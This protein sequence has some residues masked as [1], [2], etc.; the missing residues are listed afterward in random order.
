[1]AEVRFADDD[2]GEERA[3]RER[4]TEQCR[5]AEG[6]AERDREDREGEQF[7]RSRAHDTSEEPWHGAT[8]DDEHEDDEARDLGEGDRER[9]HDPAPG[10]DGSRAVR[11]VGDRLGGNRADDAGERR[12][13]DERE[14]GDE[15]LDDQPPDRDASIDRV[16]YAAV[17][18]GAEQDDRARDGEREP[19]DES[20]APRPSPPKSALTG[21]CRT[22][23]R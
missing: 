9:R 17:L 20:R 19:E 12:Q 18:E 10:I 14:D 15:I 5:R 11:G 4:D 21:E 3:E 13:E 16:E 6:E 8:A 1:M 22:P 23:P 7:A 2:A